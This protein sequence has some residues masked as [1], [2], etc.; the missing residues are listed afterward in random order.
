MKGES[1]WMVPF[2]RY[3]YIRELEYKIKKEYR[4]MKINISIFLNYMRNFI[5]LCYY[6]GGI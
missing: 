6:M 3:S 5:G 4:Y 1:A 2:L